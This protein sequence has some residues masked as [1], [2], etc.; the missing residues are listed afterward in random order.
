V[1][2]CEEM[3]NVPLCKKTDVVID[4]QKSENFV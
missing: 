1:M 2:L 3:G 4:G